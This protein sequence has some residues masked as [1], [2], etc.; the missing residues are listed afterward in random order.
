MQL[1]ASRLKLY[2]LTITE[3]HMHFLKK[4]WLDFMQS[5]PLCRM[6]FGQYQASSAA[7]GG[8]GDGNC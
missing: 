7:L 6:C 4:Y 8:L 3:P 1:V 2:G 5:H